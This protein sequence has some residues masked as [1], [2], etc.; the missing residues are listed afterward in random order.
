MLQVV[1]YGDTLS[2][3]SRTLLRD[4][5]A[6]LPRAFAVTR[7]SD[8]VRRDRARYGAMV[9]VVEA[10]RPA[11]ARFHS[12]R[13]EAGVGEV[14]ARAV[15]AALPQPAAASLHV[16]EEGGTQVLSVDKHGLRHLPFTQLTHSVVGRVLGTGRE[17]LHLGV[18]RRLKLHEAGV[19]LSL[20][21][22]PNAVVWLASV[23]VVVAPRAEGEPGVTA[24]L[25]LLL[26]RSMRVAPP[27]PGEDAELLEGDVRMLASH[28]TDQVRSRAGRRA[29][30]HPSP[31]PFPA[32]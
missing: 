3:A 28:I 23:P 22:D 2:A 16:V 17:L 30:Y 31:P 12:A 19:D 13:G 24:V 21:S 11:L 20:D 32:L 18:P 8:G 27:S 4:A 9:G 14:V 26:P 1:T 25:Q 15:S 7:R 6:C 29:G 10:L 5:L